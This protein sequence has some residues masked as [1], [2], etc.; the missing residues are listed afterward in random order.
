MYLETRMS[1]RRLFSRF[2]LEEEGQDLIE[3]AL[4]AATI[5]IAGV[6]ILPLIQARM[7]GAFSRWGSTV[8]GM[9]TPVN[10]GDRGGGPC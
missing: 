6:L 5:G 1:G 8:Q 4:L 9:C 3:Y 10:P 7:G 2:V